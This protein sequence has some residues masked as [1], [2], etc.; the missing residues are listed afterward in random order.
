MVT[1][2]GCLPREAQAHTPTAS[3]AAD[4]TPHNPTHTCQAWGAL[5]VEPGP[6]PLTAKPGVE[7]PPRS[8]WASPQPPPRGAGAAGDQTPEAGRAPPLPASQ[9]PPAPWPRLQ[10]PTQAP[11]KPCAGKVPLICG[12]ACGHQAPPAAPWPGT[13]GRAARVGLG[14]H[15]GTRGAAGR[16]RR[17]RRVGRGPA[18]GQTSPL[19][20]VAEIPCPHLGGGGGQRTTLQCQ[21][22]IYHLKKNPNPRFTNYLLS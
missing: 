16:G 14:S 6:E 8:P 7:I 11:A 21:V 3:L 22:C 12:P 4:A 9:L 19:R 10:A 5:G 15:T 18:A 17:N 13:P 1:R 2:L 20:S